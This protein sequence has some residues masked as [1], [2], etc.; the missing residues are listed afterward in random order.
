MNEFYSAKKKKNKE[1]SSLQP[2]DHNYVLCNKGL[3]KLFNGKR[4]LFLA[5]GRAEC[6]SAC[7]E[8]TIGHC[9]LNNY[10]K[11]HGS[12]QLPIQEHQNMGVIFTNASK[13]SL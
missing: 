12:L 6:N 4:K 8:C 9:I 7:A 2:L 10:T 11:N 1:K 3:N 5:W 13:K